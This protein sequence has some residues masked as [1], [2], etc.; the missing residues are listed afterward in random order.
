MATFTN[1]RVVPLGKEGKPMTVREYSSNANEPSR[2]LRVI[3]TLFKEQE[4][5]P[6]VASSKIET[7]QQVQEEMVHNS[8]IKKSIA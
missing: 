5:N 7:N 6:V 3:E 2:S 1:T 4:R 8:A